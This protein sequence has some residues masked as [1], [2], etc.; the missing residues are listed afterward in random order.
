VVVRGTY[1]AELR[2]RDESTAGDGWDHVALHPHSRLVVA[3][4]VGKRTAEATRE[5][6]ADFRAAPAGRPL[7]TRPLVPDVNPFPSATR[8]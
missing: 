1:G 7:V 8:P 4:V 2:I 5:L 6:A 3:L